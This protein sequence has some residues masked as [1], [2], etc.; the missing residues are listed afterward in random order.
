MSQLPTKGDNLAI[1]DY[2]VVRI[3]KYYKNTIEWNLTKLGDL[4]KIEKA[5]PLSPTREME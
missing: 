4:N 1:T 3:Y 5:H 2:Q